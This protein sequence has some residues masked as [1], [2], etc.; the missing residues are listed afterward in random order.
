MK[1][2]HVVYALTDPRNNEVRYI[3]QTL[4]GHTRPYRHWRTK[5]WLNSE[6]KVSVWCR[7]LLALGLEP[8]VVILEEVKGEDSKKT[9]ERFW[10]S[11]FDSLLN[12]TRGGLGIAGLDK[13]AE[14]KRRKAISKT[15]K[16]KSH[17][18]RVAAV[19]RSD[20]R[21][22]VICV[23]TGV[24]FQNTEQAAR[25]TG[26]N[27]GNLS[28]HLHGKRQSVNGLVFTYLENNNA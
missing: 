1:K 7:E 6:K 12:M 11:Q 21:R 10:V 3:G 8:I 18:H 23:N 19:M 24:I 9:R 5:L 17:P 4:Y 14:D 20:K 13:D 28:Q 16:G 15:A 27:R 2:Y 22:K 26:V 25:I